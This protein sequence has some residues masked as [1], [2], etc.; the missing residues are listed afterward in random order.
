MTTGGDNSP[1]YPYRFDRTTTAG[2][3][4]ERFGT[5]EPGAGSGHEVRVAG[6]IMSLHAHQ[7][8]RFRRSEGCNRSRAAVRPASGTG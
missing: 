4:L 2:D 8:S 3:I 5:L 7:E 6:R 1:A